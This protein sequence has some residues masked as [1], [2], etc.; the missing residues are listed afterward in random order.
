[1]RPNT[2]FAQEPHRTRTEPH[3]VR[4]GFGAG[5]IRKTMCAVRVRCV[6]IGVMFGA[7]ATSTQ[8]MVAF[9]MVVKCIW[10]G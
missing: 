3:T 2:G 4:F 9:V 1:M 7:G 10:L 8:Y 5:A 6:K